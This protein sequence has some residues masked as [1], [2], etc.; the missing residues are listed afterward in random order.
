LGSDIHF[1]TPAWEKALHEAG[2]GTASA[3]L[4]FEG[5]ETAARSRSTSV[6]RLVLPDG[7]AL[8]LKRYRYACLRD[9]VRAAFRG[10]LVGRNRAAREFEN[11]RRL[12]A[13]GLDAPAPV[14]WGARRGPCFLSA[15]FL[16]TREIENAVR[17]DALLTTSASLPGGR[18]RKLLDA[19][20]RAVSAMHGAGYT[21]GSLALRN[22]LAREEGG[23]W[24][25]FKV[26]CGKGRWRVPPGRRALEDLARF[27][28]GARGLL[29]SRERLR[30]L[31]AYLGGRLLAPARR[32]TEGVAR[33]REKYAVWEEPRLGEAAER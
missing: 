29:T 26:D 23:G 33:A 28:A 31:R 5:G 19:T 20:G 7:A 9:R 15:C 13:A 1:A 2:L 32:W 11:L 10:T 12:G 25:L 14:A 24:R 21:D 17:M 27:D 3:L 6:V 16:L 4:D 30:I 22:L 8:Y 18:R